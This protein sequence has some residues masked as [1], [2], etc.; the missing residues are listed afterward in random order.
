L[1]R[2]GRDNIV[3]ANCDFYGSGQKFGLGHRPMSTGFSVICRP[4]GGGIVFADQLAVTVFK[5]GDRNLAWGEPSGNHQW[6]A[7]WTL[8]FIV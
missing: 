3:D 8:A 2:V 1:R 6:R 7:V 4:Q 5:H